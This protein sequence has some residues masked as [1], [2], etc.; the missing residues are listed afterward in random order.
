MNCPSN[1]RAI[2]VANGRSP[3]GRPWR[4]LSCKVT[5]RLPTADEVRTHR[6]YNA[7]RR[8]GEDHATAYYEAYGARSNA[9]QLAADF[10][11][12]GVLRTA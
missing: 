9:E 7:L 12:T 6:N 4:G 8:L 2:E 5:R 10:R 3:S 11:A 1:W